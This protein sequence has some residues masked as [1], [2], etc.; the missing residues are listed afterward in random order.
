MPKHVSGDTD[1]DQIAQEIKKLCGCFYTVLS[2]FLLL[3]DIPFG[4][5][6]GWDL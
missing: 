2:L 5:G 3:K 6:G 4:L 1:V